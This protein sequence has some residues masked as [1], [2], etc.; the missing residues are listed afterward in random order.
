VLREHRE[1]ASSEVSVKGNSGHSDHRDVRNS[2]EGSKGH[3]TFSGSSKGK[4]PAKR[5]LRFRPNR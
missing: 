1:M 3:S 4:I 2:T 5:S